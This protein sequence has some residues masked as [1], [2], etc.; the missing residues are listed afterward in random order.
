MKKNKFMRLAS[1]MLMLCLITTCAI[2]GTFA[3][4]TTSASAQDS[5][6]VAKWGVKIAMNADDTFFSDSYGDDDLASDSNVTV[7][8]ESS[9]KVVAPGTKGN[10]ATVTISGK[11]EV[12]TNV[13]VTVD[14]DLGSNWKLADTT[15]Y[16][17]L[18]I[19]VNSTPYK[20][21]LSDANMDTTA[22]LE[23]AVENAIKTIIL[24]EVAASKEFAVNYNFGNDS[25][26]DLTVDWKW[27][28][29]C[30]NDPATPE[31]EAEIK[32]TNDTYLGDQAAL[33]NAPEISFNLGIVINQ[34]D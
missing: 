11:P 24:G 13:Q 29:E 6:R 18:V 33:G 20:V 28:F 31:D 7:Q 34:V 27:D 10:L 16:C 19:T 26:V 9:A 3:K 30:A 23:T 1:V 14:L 5:A 8:G 4:Y 22:E 17:P 15:V 2:S 32:D 12:K 21:N 25:T